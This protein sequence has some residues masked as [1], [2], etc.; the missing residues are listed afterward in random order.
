MAVVKGKGGCRERKGKDG[1]SLCIFGGPK[2]SSWKFLFNA[3]R[4]H[5]KSVDGVVRWCVSGALCQSIQTMFCSI[6][7]TTI[8]VGIPRNIFGLSQS[9]ICLYNS[10]IL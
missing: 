10:L 2:V 3:L 8:V 1:Q 6:F 4:I 5:P 7:F 9:H